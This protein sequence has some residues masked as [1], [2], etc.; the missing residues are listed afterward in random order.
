MLDPVHQQEDYMAKENVLER[1]KKL[2]EE[3]EKLVESAL[4]EAL[5]EAEAAVQQ[6][7][8]LGYN[9]Q[10]VDASKPQKKGTDKKR[11]TKLGTVCP[12]CEV[13]TDP[14]HDKRTH[15]GGKPAFTKAQLAE[16]GYKVIQ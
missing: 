5:K 4:G 10:L 14:P 9:Y 6:L 15:R 1:L 8:L 2:D 3:R 16:M 7:N 11:E 13:A 12:V